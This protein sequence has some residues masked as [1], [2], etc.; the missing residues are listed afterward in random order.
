[1]KVKEKE[2]RS[3]LKKNEVYKRDIASLKKQIAESASI[4]RITML[5]NQ[6]RE[7]E[8]QLAEL[9]DENKALV[10]IQRE[11]SKALEQASNVEEY[12]TKIRVLMEDLKVHREKLREIQGQ[13]SRDE[14]VLKQQHEQLVNLEEKCRKL[15]QLLSAKKKPEEDEPKPQVSESDIKDLEWKM[16]VLSEA[17]KMEE[18]KYKLKMQQAQ[19]QVKELQLQVEALSIQ[20]KEKDQECRLNALK[21]K[22]LNRTIRHNMLKPLDLAQRN[23]ISDDED[24]SPPAESNHQ[25]GHKSH[26][27]NGANSAPM[28]SAPAGK[29]AAPGTKQKSPQADSSR[30]VKSHAH[31]VDSAHGAGSKKAGAA[32]GSHGNGKKEEGS[33]RQSKL[34]AEKAGFVKD[35]DDEDLAYNDDFE[36]NVDDSELGGSLPTSPSPIDASAPTNHSSFSSASSPKMPSSEPSFSS[37]AFSP[38]EPSTLSPTSA[39]ADDDPLAAF[40]D[41]PAGG[42]GGGVF[43]KPSFMMKKKKP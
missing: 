25:S 10:R 31:E 40:I 19:L 17:K 36:S 32:G 42:S 29:A 28:A 8:K 3:A 39:K 30:N 9:Q 16:K 4:D 18:K 1:M 27:G 22:E 7:K 41:T 15:Q 23:D 34:A 12:P 20:L 2:L 21:I 5:E 43:A 14:K 6:L 11:Q 26:R 24:P 33:R 37:S 38:S 13:K 35:D